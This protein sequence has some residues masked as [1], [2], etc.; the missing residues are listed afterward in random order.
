MPATSAGM[1]RRGW[2]TPNGIALAARRSTHHEHD[3]AVGFFQDRGGGVAE[4]QLLA[5]A[6]LDAH[7]DEVMLALGHLLEDGLVGELLPANRR[8]DLDLVA[9][10]ECHHIFQN[11]VGPPSR[12]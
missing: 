5:G 1:T 9:V 12:G 4:E 7:D 10:A 3:R 11:A 8:L 6:A 2:F